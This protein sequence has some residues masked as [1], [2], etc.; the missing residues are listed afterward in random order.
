MKTGN[1]ADKI[2][3]Q[4]VVD[5]LRETTEESPA[6]PQSD[7]RE[8]FREIGDWLNHV[9]E[10][11]YKLVAQAWALRVVPFSGQH[12]VR[13]RFRAEADLHS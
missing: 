5:G 12:H 2:S 7:L 6:R 10:P 1:D 8:G 13:S 4:A 3:L 11:Q 9:F